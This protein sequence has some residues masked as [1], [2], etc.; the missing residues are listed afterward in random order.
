MKQMRTS[1]FLGRQLSA[2]IELTLDKPCS[3]CARGIACG[4][5]TQSARLPH[6]CTEAQTSQSFGNGCDR[7]HRLN[8]RTFAS[9]SI[10]QQAL[11]T[12]PPKSLE[13]TQTSD[14]DDDEQLPESVSNSAPVRRLLWL[15]GYHSAEALTIR[16]A[17]RL[18]DAVCK[19]C[20]S[21]E[22]H[23]LVDLEP[24]FYSRWCL[25]ALHMWM[26]I[27]RLNMEGPSSKPLRQELYDLF[28]EDVEVRVRQQI[29]VRISSTLEELERD[30]YGS[31][32]AMD[33]ALRGECE[34]WEPIHR[35]F[36]HSEP[37]KEAAAKMLATYAIRELQCL[38]IT[39]LDALLSGR[40]EFTDFQT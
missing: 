38:E 10:P 34:L 27:V 26:L 17:T 16:G 35:N 4:A 40:I 23:R 8:W 28:Q 2:L 12:A 6:I 31:A 5:C 14:T 9:Q 29:T 25:L 37:S 1:F 32:Q 19:Q 13:T 39:K 11:L 15:L 30:F 7:V 20:D 21:N 33:K 36:Y 22:L 3:V 24:T 18:Y